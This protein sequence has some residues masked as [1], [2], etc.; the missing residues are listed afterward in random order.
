MEP[1]PQ[2][3]IDRFLAEKARAIGQPLTRIGP[4]ERLSNGWAFSYQSR[5]YVETQDFG[6]LLVGQGPV[7]L[8]DDGRVL[9]GGSLDRDA[10][11]VLRRYDVAE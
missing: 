5:A 4:V 8:L 3:A 7:V 9:E 10:A 11:A 6:D 2:A 1:A